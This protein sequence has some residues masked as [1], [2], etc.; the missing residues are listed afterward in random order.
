MENSHPLPQEIQP[1]ALNVEL[2]NLILQKDIAW[3]VAGGL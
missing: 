1:S 2:R 3:I